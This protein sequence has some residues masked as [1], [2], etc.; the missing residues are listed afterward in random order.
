MRFPT[1]PPSC[2]WWQ[3]LLRL[4]VRAVNAANGAFYSLPIALID[5]CIKLEYFLRLEGSPTPWTKARYADS[6]QRSIIRRN[7]LIRCSGG[8][9]KGRQAGGPS[10]RC[11]CLGIAIGLSGRTAGC[12]P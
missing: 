7:N 1:P 8:K 11:D 2:S 10:P 3:V 4:V 5:L 9:K 6:M 12:V